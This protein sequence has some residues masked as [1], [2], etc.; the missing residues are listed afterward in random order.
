M[1][2]PR[3]DSGRAAM[4]MTRSTSSTSIIGVMFMSALACGIE[5]LK[6][7]SAP[8]C[9]WACAMLL[10]ASRAAG[11]GD[12]AHVLDAGGA[13]VVHRLHHGAP[14][15]VLARIDAERL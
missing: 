6:T 15:H 3:C 5:A 4:K 1:S 8:K 11:L 14:L 10:G 9:W 13:Q 12:E 7:F 2:S